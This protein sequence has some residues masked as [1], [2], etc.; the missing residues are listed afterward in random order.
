MQY[1]QFPVS[2]EPSS[3]PVRIAEIDVS[4]T[5]RASW[6]LSVSLAITPTLAVAF[7]TVSPA[8]NTS[9]LLTAIGLFLGSLEGNRNC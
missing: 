3:L 4:P 6:L 2:P 5:V 8:V 7:S 1:Q 9:R